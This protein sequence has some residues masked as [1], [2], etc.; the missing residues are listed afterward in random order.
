MKRCNRCGVEK[1]QEM[2]PKRS[3]RPGKYRTVCQS[4]ENARSRK[5]RAD[6]PGKNSEYGK[7]WR[8]KQSS[9]RLRKLRRASFLRNVENC[10]ANTAKRRARKKGLTPE[11]NRAELVEIEAM[12]MYNKIMPGD[13]E[14]DH[15]KAL[16]NGG[17]HHPS[18]L[19]VLTA[20]DNRSKGARA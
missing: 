2:F 3:D 16:A 19:Q 5:F 10:M 9:E 11:M 20:H 4:C 8:S 17:L 1:K 13:W 12:Y 7:R 14:V 15:I 18:N 6:N